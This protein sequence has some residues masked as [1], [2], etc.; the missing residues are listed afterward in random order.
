MFITEFARESVPPLAIENESITVE[1][2]EYIP[3]TAVKKTILKKS[4]E[5]K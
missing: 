2:I 1:I 4:D 3:T 5:K